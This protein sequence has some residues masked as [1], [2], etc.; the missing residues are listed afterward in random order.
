MQENYYQ[1]PNKLLVR[2]C[3]AFPLEGA[4]IEQCMF[5]GKIPKDL[6]IESTKIYRE[7]TLHLQ[8]RAKK[9]V[10]SSS[11]KPASLFSSRLQDSVE[12][13]LFPHHF[14]PACMTRLPGLGESPESW[15][16]GTPMVV[17]V[18]RWGSA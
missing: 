15:Y 2:G 4:L 13:Q 18:G 16:L 12:Q 1:N 3:N 6:S 5:V 17:G 14:R 10:G 8:N 9:L 7:D 11:R